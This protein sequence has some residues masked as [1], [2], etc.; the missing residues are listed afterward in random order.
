[1]DNLNVYLKEIS[2]EAGIILSVE[3]IE[4]LILYMEFVLEWNKKVNLTAIKDKKEFVEK[5]LLDSLIIS[6]LEE[7]KNAETIID[8]GTGGGFPGIPLAIFSPEKHFL[9]V[10]ALL[11]RT[12]IVAEGTEKFD[13]KNV[14]VLHGRGENLPLEF[15]FENGADLVVSRAVANMSKLVSYTMPN[16]RKNGFLLAYKGPDVEEEIKVSEKF[17]K[18]AGAKI[19]SIVDLSFRN[20]KHTAVICKKI[21]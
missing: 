3:Q 21:R 5:H 20:L 11:K 14:S 4:K 2:D 10:D 12:K 16:L 19:I 6:K 1:M 7:Y 15:E 17:I 13:L 9:L 8:I 18:K